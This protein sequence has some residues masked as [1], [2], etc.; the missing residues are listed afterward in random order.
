M[1]FQFAGPGGEKLE[2]WGGLQF[3]GQPGI[4]DKEP[5]G[6]RMIEISHIGAPLATDAKS[7]FVYTA[8]M[9]LVCAQDLRPGGRQLT[10]GKKFCP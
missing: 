4:E 6:S 2:N 9:H 3:E 7:A 5:L 8:E 10:L 1:C